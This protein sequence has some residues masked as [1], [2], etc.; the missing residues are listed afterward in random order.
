ME[1]AV[2]VLLYLLIYFLLVGLPV[3]R[4]LSR[5]GLSRWATIFAFIPVVNIAGLWA[6]AYVEWP[7]RPSTGAN[8]GRE[9]SENDWKLFKELERRRRQ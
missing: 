9:W 8:E 5:L 6:L 2:L 7:A 4:I 1:E 3:A